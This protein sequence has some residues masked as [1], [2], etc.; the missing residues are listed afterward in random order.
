MQKNRRYIWTSTSRLKD[1]YG[2][3]ATVQFS[4]DQIKVTFDDGFETFARREHIRVA[5]PNN[6]R[7][8]SR[9]SEKERVA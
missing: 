5:T 9:P 4:G 8:Y 3:L 7:R 6:L 2:T 1:R